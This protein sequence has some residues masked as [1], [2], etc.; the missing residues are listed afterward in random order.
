MAVFDGRRAKGAEAAFGVNR[1]G[2]A[3]NGQNDLFLFQQTGEARA[4]H[5]KVGI[6]YFE[7]CIGEL[8]GLYGEVLAVD[9]VYSE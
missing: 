8:E 5:L 7:A 6:N 9:D 4:F 1:D 3:A 2:F